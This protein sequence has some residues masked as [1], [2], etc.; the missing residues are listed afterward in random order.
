MSASVWVLGDQLLET[1]PAIQT[2]EQ[3][4]TRQDVTVLLI[5]SRAQTRRMPYH[6]KKLV[7][8][9]S[10]MRHYAEELREAGFLVDYRVAES[11]ESGLL[12][13]FIMNPSNT[14]FTME[15]SSVGGRRFQSSLSSL[16]NVQTVLVPN[17]Q[18]LCE[19]FD[20]LP[21]VT[22][23]KV[24]RQEQFYRKIRQH[25]SLLID[26]QGQPV[27]GQWNYDQKNRQ[28]LPKTLAV[29]K[30]QR[31]EPDL[32]TQE[33]MA[34]VKQHAI[35]T[36]SEIGF[37]L[38]VTREQAKRA[39][40]D[41]LD[42]RLPN[43]GTYEDGMRQ[44]ESVLFH[45]KLAQYLNIG[46]L[47]PLDLAR[48]AEQRYIEGSVAINNV[49]GFIRQVIGWREY[50]YWQYQRLMPGLAEGNY[51]EAVNPLPGFFWNA[52]ETRMNCLKKVIGGV[53]RSGYAHHI[54]RLMVLSNFCL[55]AG[56]DPQAVYEWF[57]CAF[58]DAYEWVM[59][60]N[61]Y[62]MGLYADGG[63]VGSKPYIA[64]ANYINRMSDYCTGCI[65][66]KKQRTGQGACPYNFLYW[67]FLLKHQEKLVQNNR[68]A[69]MLH[70]LRFLDDDER[71]AVQNQADAFIE[72]QG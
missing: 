72:H 48:A 57:S 21:D 2:A 33:V 20:P 26:D 29:P 6:A 1:H 60:P 17:T 71:I 52:D 46:L 4:F 30:Y 63:M 23:E 53:L 3:Q 59:V 34:E 32:V 27:G 15:A 54:E 44:D 50:M 43:F 37:D 62:G 67:Q 69:R 39:L 61:V 25:F 38:G 55:L 14:L 47:D 36:G 9:F 45:S 58:I 28:P 56:I 7:L 12:A 49:E 70:N 22:A 65:Y 18:F 13:H 11:T 16:L 66:D 35:H 68:M 8:L 51:F 64:S 10:A 31:I 42:N 40:V 24:I 5:E 41:F 19:R